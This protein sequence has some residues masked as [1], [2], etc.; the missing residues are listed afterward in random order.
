MQGRWQGSPAAPPMWVAMTVLLLRIACQHDHGFQLVS[1]ISHLFVAF[2][3][4]MYV[5]DTDL[6]TMTKHNETDTQLCRRTQHLADRWIDGLYATGAVLRPGKRWW[7]FISLIWE[8]SKWRYREKD[9]LDFEL[10]VP[11]VHGVMHPVRQI[12]H[13]SQNRTLGVRM[14]GN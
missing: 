7:L 4:I 10:L 5:D 3:A 9:E 1:A 8:G 14:A 2:S 11:D 12:N 13:D 6:F